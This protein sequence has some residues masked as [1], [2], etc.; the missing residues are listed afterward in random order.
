MSVV[1]CMPRHFSN[2]FKKYPMPVQLIELGEWILISDADRFKRMPSDLF[3]G[4]GKLSVFSLVT[5]TRIFA[6]LKRT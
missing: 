3:V 4:E 6:G 5:Q 2:N 1:A